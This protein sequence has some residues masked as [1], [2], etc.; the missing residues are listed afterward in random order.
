[1]EKK[2]RRKGSERKRKGKPGKK[3]SQ[4]M[5]REDEKETEE[6][7]KLDQDVINGHQNDNI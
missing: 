3:K 4:V 6:R 1:M 2:R 5:G 7:R